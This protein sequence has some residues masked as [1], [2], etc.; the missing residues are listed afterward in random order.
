LP[1]PARADDAGERGH[2]KARPASG[3]PDFQVI[4]VAKF[5]WVNYQDDLQQAGDLFYWQLEVQWAADDLRKEGKLLPKSKSGK[6]H[7][8]LA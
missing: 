6:G 7:L 4:D 2:G 8:Q 5:I 1:R 3:Q